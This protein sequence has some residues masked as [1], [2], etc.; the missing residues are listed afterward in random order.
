MK[1]DIMKRTSLL[2]LCLLLTANAGLGLQASAGETNSISLPPPGASPS[3]PL[4]E[5]LA[6]RQTVREFSGQPL[7]PEALS[8]LL[9]AAFGINRPDSAKRTAPSAMN[10]QEMA[11]YVV[12]PQGLYLYDAKPHRLAK[13]SEGDLRRSISGQAFATN[14]A[15]IL[16]FVAD[17]A[18]LDKAPLDQREFYAAFDAG[19]IAQ[20]VY[21]QCAAA[22]LGSVVFELDREALHKRMRLSESQKVI[23]AQAVGNPMQPVPAN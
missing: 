21:L 17:L 16:V 13:L 2:H 9:W 5:C 14:A 6:Q 18:K 7:S 19:C 23:M 1:P 12:M 10:S 8:S 15:A 22:G 4:F 20:N 11:L 3:K